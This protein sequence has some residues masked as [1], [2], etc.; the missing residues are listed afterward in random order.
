MVSLNATYGPTGK[1][2]PQPWLDAPETK[3][4]IGAL[5]AAGAEVR[6]IGGCVRDAMANHPAKLIAPGDV[7]IATP[8][9]PETV[10]RLLQAAGIKVLPTGIKHGTVTAVFKDMKFE[11]T[12]LRL[13][14]DTDG[15][16]ATVAFTELE[17]E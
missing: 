8:D 1:L 7:D 16:R 4:V 5:T 13:D 17:W 9:P 2:S 12:T 11:I 6:F 14:V 3:T 10:T 15:R